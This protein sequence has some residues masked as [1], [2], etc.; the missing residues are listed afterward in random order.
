M[1]SVWGWMPEL[2]EGMWRHVP[3]W[4]RPFFAAVPWITA[5]AL[6]LMLHMVGGTLTRAEGVLFDLPSGDLSDGE[7]TPLVALV[8]P[9]Q[10]EACVFFDD[11][12]Y[13]LDDAASAAALGEHLA[14]RAAKVEAK[15][16]LVL[17]DRRI[18]CDS[19]SKVASVARR[20]GL[21]RILFAN[22]SDKQEAAA[23]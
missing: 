8:L 5:G 23:E 10:N 11:A 6:L 4:L 18:T 7:A 22:K 12:R 1:K 2:P 17:S 16:L 19:I 20:N 9:L 21:E 15:S 14:E 3:A 13:S